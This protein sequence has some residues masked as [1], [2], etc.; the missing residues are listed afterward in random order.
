[1]RPNILAALTIVIGGLISI[2]YLIYFDWPTAGNTKKLSDLHFEFYKLSLSAMIVGGTLFLFQQYQSKLKA[3]DDLRSSIRK[4]ESESFRNDIKMAQN[5][6]KTH[7]D[8]IGKLRRTRTT[9]T[10]EMT[11]VPNTG[12]FRVTYAELLRTGQSIA[13]IVSTLKQEKPEH[14]IEFSDRLV[15]RKDGSYS[16]DDELSVSAITWATYMSAFSELRNALETAKKEFEGCQ[17]FLAKSRPDFV[18]ISKD[19]HFA[20]LSTQFYSGD[21]ARYLD[22]CIPDL[23]ELA[24]KQAELENLW[25]I[26][27]KKSLETA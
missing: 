9:F 12:Y 19:S 25:T 11:A 24:L 14:T 17:P 16:K 4:L 7:R 8:C 20:A 5:V 26:N 23:K 22:M 10:H 15:M 6:A 21:H 18:L 2:F 27:F 1:M 3:D 13:E